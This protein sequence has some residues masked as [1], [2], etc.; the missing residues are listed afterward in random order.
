MIS[1]KLQLSEGFKTIGVNR[2]KKKKE[3][4]L[5]SNMEFCQGG[6]KG[7]NYFICYT[8]KENKYISLYIHRLFL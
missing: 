6:G 4:S 2:L 8:L 7:Q 1:D 5:C 3:G